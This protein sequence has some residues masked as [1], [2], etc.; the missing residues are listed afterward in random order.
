MRLREINEGRDG[1]IWVPDSIA[2]WEGGWDAPSHWERE[3]I[4]SMRKHLSKGMTLFDVGVEHGWM[5]ILFAQMVDPQNM[6]LIEPTPGMWQDIA[7]TWRANFP[8]VE[9]LAC[10]PGLLGAERVAKRATFQTG[11]PSWVDFNGPESPAGLDYRSLVEDRD[12]EKIE[13]STIDVLAKALK[14]RVDAISIDVE[15][16]EFEVLKGGV[17]T[18]TKDRPLVWVSVH[19]DMLER[20]YNV[21][22][23]RTIYQFMAD[24]GYGREYLGTDHEQHHFFAPNERTL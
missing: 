10:W 6:V 4:D 7:L 23:V 5:N 2:D 16:A 8:D 14:I 9:P 11:W 3:R 19:P 13:T 21:P 20:N 18:L 17:K 15:G 1:T 12:G 22:D 24:L